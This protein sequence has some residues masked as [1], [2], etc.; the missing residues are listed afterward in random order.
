MTEN[1]PFKDIP[2]LQ[3]QW[4]E[5]GA[6][7]LIIL[8]RFFVRARLVGLRGLKGDDYMI[9]MVLGLFTLDAVLVH[10]LAHLGTNMDVP[11][12]LAPDE[13]GPFVLGSKLLLVSWYSY[14]AILW[15]LKGC[16]L[17]FYKRLAFGL[18]QEKL[19]RWLA[20]ACLLSYIA[21]VLTI[22]FSCWPYAHN[23]MVYPASNDRCG[24][25]TQNFIVTCVLNV[26]T[27]AALLFIPLPLV[28]KVKV[29][30]KRKFLLSIL[31][32]SGIFVMA[33]SII[34]TTLSLSGTPSTSNVVKWGVRETFMGIITT[35]MPILKPLV[36]KAFWAK[37]S[38][39]TL[40]HQ[41]HSGH[42][43]NIIQPRSTHRIRKH[44]RGGSPSED[45]FALDNEMYCA[46]IE[47]EQVMIT[48]TV[49]VQVHRETAE[50]DSSQNLGTQTGKGIHTPWSY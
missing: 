21:V 10:Q 33:A 13:Y 36:T 22:T 23:W 38:P 27:D 18:W 5:Y 44:R 41:D 14:T 20:V 4:A 24:V 35:N 39:S 1:H 8:L 47:G 26:V 15:G 48:T 17:F 43:F 49:D 42:E 37:G 19:A 28:W 45:G 16:M 31:F 3:E 46:G 2:L 30:P 29:T 34:R 40:H 32:S 12:N 6:G 7:I 9:V 50:P 25:K 11:V